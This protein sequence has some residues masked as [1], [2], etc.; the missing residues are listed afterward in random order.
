MK[1]FSRKR[2][3][4][5]R[6]YVFRPFLVVGGPEGEKEQ[7]FV[8]YA[9]I[10]YFCAAAEAGEVRYQKPEPSTGWGNTGKRQLASE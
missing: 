7:L 6:F 4:A 8:K 9:T 3:A 5:E 1:L 2:Y 10:I